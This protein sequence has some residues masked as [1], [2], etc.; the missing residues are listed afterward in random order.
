MIKSMHAW[1]HWWYESI[2]TYYEVWGFNAMQQI[3]EWT[4][5]GKQVQ[6]HNTNNSMVWSCYTY[7][8]I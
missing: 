8:I 5:G 1:K 2:E 3:G 7:K 6:S 4:K